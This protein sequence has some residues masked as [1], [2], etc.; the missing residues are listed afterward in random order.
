MIPVQSED[1]RPVLRIMEH[2]QTLKHFLARL[3]S[4]PDM[5]VG[6]AQSNQ[7][8]SIV[9]PGIFALWPKSAIWYECF[10][11]FTCNLCLYSFVCIRVH[12]RRLNSPMDITLPGIG[13]K[14]EIKARTTAGKILQIQFAWQTRP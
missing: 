8:S 14:M 13:I 1:I 9:P 7:K 2:V 12:N 4:L 5:L 3:E 11:D 6:A 10:A